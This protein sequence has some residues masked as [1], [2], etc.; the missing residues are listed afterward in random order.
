[1]R[2]FFV[3]AAAIVAGM[4]TGTAQSNALSNA[5]VSIVE[6]AKGN[7]EY[8]RPGST[9]TSR[10]HGGSWLRIVTDEIGYGSNAQARLLGSPLREVRTQPLCKIG[11]RTQP[12][13]GRGAVIGYRRTWDA[14]GHEGGNFEFLVI[15]NGVGGPRR[16]NFQVR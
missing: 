14:S 10:D 8:V 6:S 16:V 15:P 1:M 5:Y 7:T 11:G 9:V 13:S 3:A 12:C 2:T 4:Q